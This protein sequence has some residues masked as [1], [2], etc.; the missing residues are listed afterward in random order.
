MSSLSHL[1]FSVRFHLGYAPIAS[2]SPCHGLLTIYTAV[3]MAL[4]QDTLPTRSL[5]LL[6]LAINWKQ[7]ASV[8]KVF[9]PNSFSQE[10]NENTFLAET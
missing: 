7:H 2:A 5:H 3:P 6:P 4:Q 1:P 10:M 8:T 9:L